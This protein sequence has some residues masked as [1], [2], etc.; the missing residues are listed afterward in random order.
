MEIV[1]SLFIYFEIFFWVAVVMEIDIAL[2]T[3]YIYVINDGGE[4]MGKV[5]SIDS[6]GDALDAALSSGCGPMMVP[7]AKLAVERYID[8]IDALAEQGLSLRRIYEIMDQASPLGIRLPYFLRL[9]RETRVREGSRMY[10]SREERKETAK[11]RREASRPAPAPKVM[12]S[13][14][15]APKYYCANCEKGSRPGKLHGVDLYQCPDC[16]MVYVAGKNG[17]ITPELYRPPKK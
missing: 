3:I 2:M 17:E 5:D 1:K 9:V 7:T 10:K 15:P 16:K 14:A 6:I 11:Q 8:K 12:A 4:S 13:P